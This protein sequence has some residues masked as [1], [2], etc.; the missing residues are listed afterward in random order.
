M[1]TE[2]FAAL[3]EGDI[4]FVDTTHTVRTG[5]DVVHIF[6][7]I[8]PRPAQ[9]VIVH[10]H[11]IFLPY[12]YPRDWVVDRRRAWAE[13]YLLQ[14]FLAFNTTF[15]VLMPNYAIARSAPDTLAQLGPKFRTGGRLGGF[16]LSYR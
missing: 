13:Q 15:E 2:Q 14:A 12:E 9:G 3:E 7:Q 4:L 10:I 1:A 6:L 11:D 16:W 5:G 8:L